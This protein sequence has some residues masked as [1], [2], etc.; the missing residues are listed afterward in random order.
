MNA[1]LISQ[2]PEL[3][4]LPPPCVPVL[5]RVE[6]T[7]PRQQERQELR[8]VLRQVLAAWSG[9][10]PEQLPLGETAHGPVWREQLGDHDLDISL[11]YTKG[12]GWI[13]LLRAGW[14]GVDVMPIQIVPEAEAVARL[15]FEPEAWK[16]IQQSAHPALAFATKWTTLEARLK[17]L[18]R[19]LT[20]L[21]ETQTMEPPDCTVQSTTLPGSQILTI[22]TRSTQKKNCGPANP[23]AP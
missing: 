10:P 16:T 4:A 1:A 19:G 7:S 21:S 3:P 2:W 22:A 15:Y 18:K 13:G 14:I 20:E 11:S 9:L 8:T 5:I 12:E 6:T 23:L 17:C